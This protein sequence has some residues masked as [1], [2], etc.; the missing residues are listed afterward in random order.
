MTKSCFTYDISKSLQI[1]VNLREFA[2][3]YKNFGKFNDCVRTTSN[4]VVRLV[5]ALCAWL[6]AWSPALLCDS[7]KIFLSN[8]II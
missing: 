1:F 8:N 2:S 6:V 5:T 7:P 4:K 3:V